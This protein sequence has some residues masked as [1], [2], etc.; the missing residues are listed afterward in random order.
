MRADVVLGAERLGRKGASVRLS[1]AEGQ[2]QT[3]VAWAGVEFEREVGTVLRRPAFA[4]PI[5]LTMNAMQGSL[6][7]DA[8]LTKLLPRA[9][10]KPKP[11]VAL[12]DT[13]YW[14][15][16]SFDCPCVAATACARTS[17]PKMKP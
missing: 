10:W 8:S 14:A 7:E 6:L 5:P 9:Q 12:S 11:I 3:C 4:K 15:L 2:S 13:S 17:A 1:E 16:A